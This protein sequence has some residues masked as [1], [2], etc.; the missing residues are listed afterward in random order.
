MHVKMTTE[1]LHHAGVCGSYR[2]TFDR[3]FP[4]TE[5][6]DGV[7]VTPEVCEG[8][9]DQFDW[10]S[11]RG[12]FLNDKGQRRHR[13]ALNRDDAVMTSIREE[14]E[15]I[16]H[17][18]EAALTAWQ[19]RYGQSNP[20]TDWDTPDVARDAMRELEET[21]SQRVN[22]NQARISQHAARAFAELVVQSEYQR[23]DL[24][25]LI[26]AAENTRARQAR[27]EL[28]DA[29]QRVTLATQGIEDARRALE[30]HT[31]DLPLAERALIT[32]RA[33]F[34]AAEVKRAQARA[35]AVIDAVTEA[36]KV[37]AEAADALAK[38]DA[39]ST[40][41]ATANAVEAKV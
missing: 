14:T 8:V 20:W 26:N 18:R 19:T 41:E 11:A 10:S 31:A 24:N 39:P 5:Y 2:S 30:R 7:D 17:E 23:R 36:E 37:A 6:P 33:A 3:L 35:Q 27:Q 32:V 21:F 28:T 38:L 13:V 9:A 40:D 34:T 22:A 29:E 25:E 4:S 1:L 12:Y 16:A 15:Q